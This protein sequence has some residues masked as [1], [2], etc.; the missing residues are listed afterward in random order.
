[1][2]NDKAQNP[3]EKKGPACASDGE[4]V[5]TQGSSEPRYLKIFTVAEL[6]VASSG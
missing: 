5:S 6:V 4:S 1:M 3:N 2:T